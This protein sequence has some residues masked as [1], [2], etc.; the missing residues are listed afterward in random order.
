MC[1]HGIFTDKFQ[2]DSGSRAGMTRPAHHTSD[3]EE[4]R[5]FCKDEIPN[6]VGNDRKAGMTSRYQKA[7]TRANDIS[8]LA[9]ESGLSISSIYFKNSTKSK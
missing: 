3:R 7:N 6:Q 8:Y 9:I 5:L 2:G 1:I 4:N